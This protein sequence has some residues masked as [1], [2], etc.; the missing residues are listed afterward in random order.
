LEREREPGGIPRHAHHQGY[1]LRDLRR[2]LSG[3]RYARE[4]T[5][6]AVAA[7]AE[8][9]IGAQAT[10]WSRDTR[11]TL[12]VTAPRGRHLIAAR[13]IVLATGCRERARSARLVAGTRPQ[14]IM[15]TGTLQQLVY[16][17]GK[18]VGTRAV[19]IGAEHVSFSAL[20]TLAHGGARPVAMTTELAHHQSY[21]AFRAGAALRFRVPVLT[22][23]AVT[24]IRGRK[25][26]EA[27][28][29][30]DLN[31]G[32]T[33]EI[34]CDLVV[35]TADWIPDHELAVLG[36]VELDPGTRGPRIDQACRTNVPGIFAAGNVLHGAETADVAA[37]SG[38][39]VAK[40]VAGWLENASWPQPPV[41]I[42][43]EEPLHWVAPNSIVVGD[44]SVARNRF[45]LRARRE[46]ISPRIEIQ[47]GHRRLWAG[48]LA[49]VTAG[50]SARIPTAWLDAVD[51]DRGAVTIRVS[52]AY[53]RSSGG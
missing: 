2:P 53:S 38:R 41:S 21:A 7:G 30:T 22:R 6:R 29:I 28:E 39:H 3:P 42:R 19:V 11:L 13:A 24:G 17:C 23:A 14:G 1:G 40:A 50:R 9:L 16:L 18:K 51:A 10:G 20:M 37:L 15:T 49:R 8:I 4:W 5:S 47:Q 33:R 36:G 31:T 45:L 34:A 27:V 26:V 44:R 46:L 12:E 43:C 32:S 25:Q 52:R 35:F 48:R